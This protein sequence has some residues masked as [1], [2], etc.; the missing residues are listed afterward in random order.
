MIRARVHYG[1]WLRGWL[2]E[3]AEDEDWLTGRTFVKWDDAMQWAN[4]EVRRRRKA[5]AFRK[6]NERMRDLGETVRKLGLA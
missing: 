3:V 6:F 4:D 1:R 5:A 2:V